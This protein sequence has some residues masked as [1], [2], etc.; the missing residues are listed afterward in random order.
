[1]TKEGTQNAAIKWKSPRPNKKSNQESRARTQCPRFVCS[2]GRWDRQMTM[3]RTIKR[4]KQKQQERRGLTSSCPVRL[5]MTR[6]RSSQI[7]IRT[8]SRFFVVFERLLTASGHSSPREVSELVVEGKRKD[9]RGG[10]T[11]SA[12]LY[13]P[14]WQQAPKLCLF[15]I[16]HRTAF[17]TKNTANWTQKQTTELN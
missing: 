15:P 12:D 11:D 14:F 17:W 3:T 4:K 2:R 13:N 1:M 9:E 6:S 16:S 8:H 5:A 7:Y 10:T